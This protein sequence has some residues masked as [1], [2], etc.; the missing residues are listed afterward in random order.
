MI[1]ECQHGYVEGRSTATNLMSFVTCVKNRIEK[2]HQVDAIY[3][4]FAKAFD[5]VPHTLTIAKL[6]KMGLPEW[7]IAWL[8]SY[9]TERFAFVK[10]HGY[11]SAR[12]TIPSGVPQGSHLGP[13]L[14]VLFIADL[15]DLIQSEKLFYADDLKIFKTILS[16]MD[17]CVIQRDLDTIRNWC[18]A[19]G[20]DT[21]AEKCKVISFT[22]SRAPIQQ[23]YSIGVHEL[24]RVTSVKDLGVV[25]DNKVTF[26]EH[27]AT[28]TAKAFSLLGF[29]RRI[30][31][32]FQDVYALKSIYCTVVRSVLEYAV[33]V[34]SPYHQVQS[35]RVERVQ[36][37][38][39]RYALRRL[40][41]N[42]SI[43]LPP[44]EHRCMLIGLDTLASRRILLQR[45]FCFDLL[46]GNID[47]GDLLQQL[48]IHVPNRRL[49]HPT[50]LYIPTHRTLYGHHNPLH[51]CCRYFNDVYDKFDFNITKMTFKNRLI[52]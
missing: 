48:N 12:F 34:W 38:F 11:E 2:K 37:S 10:V 5:K 41:W 14:F 31:K 29:L 20:M 47:C 51:S 24:D 45:V 30:T 4:D 16:Q 9:L 32:S 28:T 39:L 46:T 36:K 23:S 1:P 33:Q 19:N 7:I 6:R 42:D 44:Y 17:C 43:R 8:E 35:N 3:I 52:H 22:R 15:C 18:S 50:F 49:R 13:L 40:P 25:V 26:N 21:N 27:I